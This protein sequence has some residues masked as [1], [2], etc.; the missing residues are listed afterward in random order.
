MGEIT[1]TVRDAV[2]LDATNWQKVDFENVGSIALSCRS[3]VD[4]Y[5]ATQADP[6]NSYFTIDAGQIFT[7]NIKN[8]QFS[9]YFK[10]ASGPVFLEIFHMTPEG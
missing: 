9:L 4:I 6:G 10:A 8:P 1:A 7:P 3:A 2:G 5:V